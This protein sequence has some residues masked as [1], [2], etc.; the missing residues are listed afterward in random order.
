VVS[1]RELIDWKRLLTSI[2]VPWTDHGANV[3]RDSVNIACPFCGNDPSFHLGI[4]LSGHGY[5]CFRNSSHGGRNPVTLLY[6][7][8]IARF[9]AVELL[10][11]YRIA[12]TSDAPAEAPKAVQ[13]AAAWDNFA[14][15]ANHPPCLAY[16]AAR[17]CAAPDTVCA[18][19]NLRYAPVGRWADR[20]LFPLVNQQGIAG[21]T[22]RSLTDRQPRYLTQQDASVI[23]VPAPITNEVALLVE[24]PFDALK[25]SIAGFPC[26]A[27]LGLAI[28]DD[29]LLTLRHYLR[30]CR[31][32]LVTWDEGVHPISMLENKKRLAWFLRPLYVARLA[33]PQGAE[34]PGAMSVAEIRSWL[35]T[36]LQ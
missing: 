11:R 27:S 1:G 12:Y 7:L 3:G 29:R 30:N 32:V 4:S 35:G 28:N 15:A 14:N 34:D 33:L 5:Y 13:S 25:I 6:R 21:W 31:R 18:T 16:L 36:N 9:S 8:G 22:G 24:G 26:I 2:H 20:L 19:Y 10:N 17:G 23:Y